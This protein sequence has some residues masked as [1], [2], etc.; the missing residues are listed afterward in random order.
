MS[1]STSQQIVVRGWSGGQ[2]AFRVVSQPKVPGNPLLVFYIEVAGQPVKLSPVTLSRATRLDFWAREDSPDAALSPGDF[3][4]PKPVWSVA[5][6]TGSLQEF[7]VTDGGKPAAGGLRLTIRLLIRTFFLPTFGDG[8][9][10]PELLL[11]TAL[12]HGSVGDPLLALVGCQLIRLEPDPH[13]PPGPPTSIP[14]YALLDPAVGSTQQRFPLSRLPG[15]R[16]AL[17]NKLNPADK[18]FG[19][20]GGLLPPLLQAL[21]LPMKRT[22]KRTAPTVRFVA[23]PTGEQQCVLE[24]ATWF[25]CDG[26]AA[27]E[28]APLVLL[29][30]TKADFN[31]LEQMRLVQRQPAGPLTDAQHRA[32]WLFQLT[33]PGQTMSRRWSEWVNALLRTALVAVEGSSNVT[34]L[35][36]FTSP[37]KAAGKPVAPW[38]LVY[39]LV[40]VQPDLPPLP[41]LPSVLR[42][43]S[44]FY[45]PTVGEPEVPAKKIGLYA[46]LLTP[47][48]LR[49]PNGVG[50]P[51]GPPP[52][53]QAATI[54]LAFDGL[55]T[56]E[57]GTEPPRQWAALTDLREATPAEAT[58]QAEDLL[59]APIPELTVG[60]AGWVF[61]AKDLEA[62]PR[63]RLQGL[64][65][66]LPELPKDPAA[67]LREVEAAL[68]PYHAQI[69]LALHEAYPQRRLVLLDVQLALTVMR[70]APGGQDD[71]PGEDLALNQAEGGV[72]VDRPAALIMPAAAATGA[73]RYELKAV[74]SA[75]ATRS[76]SITLQLF[77]QEQQQVNT[78]LF[79]LDPEP[80]SLV[81]VVATYSGPDTDTTEIGNYGFRPG[82][83]PGWNIRLGSTSF[84]LLLPPQAL[85]EGMHR[86]KAAA[87]VSEGRPVQARFGQPAR[88]RLLASEL[89]Q[90]YADLPWDLRRRLGYPGQ[91]AAG[92]LLES[93]DVELVYG[94]LCE[95][96]RPG[97]RLAEIQARLGQLPAYLAAALPWNVASPTQRARYARY[98]QGWRLTLAA[99]RSRPALWEPY[100]PTNRPDQPGATETL[101]LRGTNGLKV[102]LD[103][104][105]DLA[106]PVADDPG[107]AG[108]PHGTLRGSFAWAFE[109][110]NVYNQL[111][112]DPAATLDS[113]GPVADEA[114]LSA[115]QLSPLGG[116]GQV[117]A[118]FGNT[119]II[120][121]VAM[122]RL[123]RLQVERL[124]RITVGWNRARHVIVY[125]RTV[126]ASRQF[127][128]EQYS[129]LGSP[130]LRKT[131][132][133]VEIG[134]CERALV[135][136]PA[137]EL[138]TQAAGLAQALLF[139]SPD[140]QPV[141][142]RVASSW[143]RD[144]GQAGWKVPLWRPGAAPADVYPKPDVRLVCTA[145]QPGQ[146]TACPIDDPDKLYFFTLTTTTAP[147]DQWGAVQGVDF[148][149][150]APAAINPTSSEQAIAP[151]LDAYTLTMGAARPLNLVSARQEKAVAALL[152]TVVV[153]RGP[154][155]QALTTT[156]PPPALQAARAVAEQALN[157]LLPVRA[158]LGQELNGQPL[159]EAKKALQDRLEKAEKALI[160]QVKSVAE[161]LAAGGQLAQ[162]LSQEITG[163]VAGAY[164]IGRQAIYDDVLHLF[165]EAQ[166]RIKELIGKVKTDFA[167]READTAAAAARLRQELRQLLLN[168]A[169][170]S[171]EHELGRLRR[172]AGEIRNLLDEATRRLPLLQAAAQLQLQ[173]AENHINQQL[174][175]HDLEKA[176]MRLA[177]ALQQLRDVAQTAQTLVAD[178]G[179]RWLGERPTPLLAQGLETAFWQQLEALRYALQAV[180]PPGSISLGGVKAALDAW[181]TQLPGEVA[182][183][184]E[185]IIM[186]LPTSELVMDSPG[187]PTQRRP[188][189]NAPLVQLVANWLEALEK[190]ILDGQ[191]FPTVTALAND[192]EVA[193]TEYLRQLLA[194]SNDLLAQAVT[195]LGQQAGHEA[196]ALA[197]LL[198]TEKAKLQAYFEPAAERLRQLRDLGQAS[199]AELH[200]LLNT[201]TT[202]IR[203]RA[204]QLVELAETA[205]QDALPALEVPETAATLLR[206]FGQPPRVPG[207]DF[208]R[209]ALAGMAY[210]FVRSPRQA[211]QALLESAREV[212]FTQAQAFA[213]AAE[214]AL[215]AGAKE[216]L[217]LSLSF[218]T[219]ELTSILVPHELQ[220]L[221]VASVFE[222]LAGL[223]LKLL[224]ASVP[225]PP[226]AE[227]KVRHEDDPQT[228]AKRVH[229]EV[230]VTFAQ[231]APIFSLA[232]VTL[233]LLPGTTLTAALD[234]VT[235]PGEPPRTRAQGAI[236]GDW[237]L[238]LGGYPLV[239]LA[240]TTLRFDESGRLSFDLTPEHVQLQQVLAFISQALARLSTGPS[241]LSLSASAA[242]VF[243]NLNLPLPNVQAGTFGL[244]NLNLSFLFGLKLTADLTILTGLS[245]GRRTA[246]FT[247]TVFVLGGAGWLETD[248]AYVP[249]TGKAIVNVSIALM[250]SAGLAVSLGPIS[251]SIYAY[252]GITAEYHSG[253]GGGLTLGI[254]LLFTGSVSLLGLVEVSLSLVLQVDYRSGLLVGRGR[255]SYRIKIGWFIN[256][257]VS[258]GVE[259]R[260]GKAQTPAG[261]A[262]PALVADGPPPHRQLLPLPAA[263]YAQAAADYVA[264]FDFA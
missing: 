78:D 79:I 61:A 205:L 22:Y 139:P 189:L 100:E 35:P 146:R 153:L 90:R 74:E 192:A 112:G 11:Q 26:A 34:F 237:S 156:L 166:A 248:V 231:E 187:Q 3:P 77:Q 246:P 236:F 152:H 115:L 203:Q 204:G 196:A 68:P 47:T 110:A 133:Y 239:V 135:D 129:L 167:G 131:E 160:D 209:D 94:I 69:R 176:R 21:G 42:K 83:G 228:R 108:V 149:D 44:D 4:P 202:E 158:L 17:I 186:Q 185:A 150:I 36:T 103:R 258:A 57:A 76:H 233:T 169:A 191:H 194:T 259:Y 81:R 2:E 245:I 84:E 244:A 37:L 49:A 263:D 5:F 98:S 70:L 154:V 113:P 64:E 220:N 168:P 28:V 95:V 230:L 199:V 107:L 14:L 72:A 147:P 134:Q 99:L 101:N 155:R 66:Q 261:G 224:F 161:K 39:L 193:A 184:W 18:D 54:V 208:K 247:L 143:G 171:L 222:H 223:P 218:P 177:A 213:G 114:E 198:I 29:P 249:A 207:L 195:T 82:Q 234:I 92:A 9:A 157:A 33:I 181:L 45:F 62:G 242:G 210:A 190:H 162:Q 118:R 170:G 126:A 260:M 212:A 105:A 140:G 38:E 12:E 91:R 130:L 65:A 164:Q 175:L 13:N 136:D 256:I 20:S 144:V 217:P 255:V 7:A 215:I 106:Y 56:M 116:S 145:D 252:F 174:A 104:R 1:T 85:A 253:A 63:L 180:P 8:P 211:G 172:T 93:L 102:S 119:V 6:P 141:R 201:A 16:F 251:G 188:V 206:A 48:S 221:S 225:M 53:P 117:R 148:E 120:A 121:S 127:Y 23:T 58:R 43:A 31:A 51:Q 182:K 111:W 87:D 151:G 183:T 50:V 80:F 122:G 227:L 27:A 19:T 173:E 159:E 55:R 124:G 179:R 243:A 41:A 97:L 178:I 59:L 257:K 86:S 200:Q 15:S 25:A 226:N 165:Q 75:S 142:I 88:V 10:W 32:R 238:R 250:A 262:P 109:S 197:G 96:T 73:G 24:I 60:F 125:E 214:R 40:D 71:V 89:G 254:M 137:N 30:I 219:Q 264:M 235:V 163:R 52:T 138:R 46:R 232:G 123:N 132:E 128:Q 67:S 229:A 240:Q 241:G 216:L